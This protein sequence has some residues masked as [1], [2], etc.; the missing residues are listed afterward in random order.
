MKKTIKLK[1]EN[2]GN[3]ELQDSNYIGSGGEAN[4][5]KFNKYAVKVYH[6]HTKAI[7]KTKIDELSIIKHNNVLKPLHVAYNEYGKLAGY[8]MGFIDGSEPACKMFTKSFKNNN[9]ISI[10]DVTDLVKDIKAC[11]ES[12]HDAKC[13]VVDMN[14]MNIVLTGRKFNEPF[15]IDVD[16]YQTPTFKATAIMES[17]RDRQVKNHQWTEL[18]DW[19]SYAIL[20]FQMY[21]GIHPYKGTHPKYKANEWMVRMEDGVS[22]FDKKVSLPAVCNDFKVIPSRYLDWMKLLF[23]DNRR[24]VPPDID[25]SVPLAMPLPVKTLFVKGDNKFDYTVVEMFGV[26]EEVLDAINVFGVSYYVTNKS[27]YKGNARMVELDSSN[28]HVAVTKTKQLVYAV[29]G[30]RALDIHDAKGMQIG[31]FDCRYSNVMDDDIYIGLGSKL[32]RVQMVEI[33]S[34]T[35]VSLYDAANIMELSTK[36]FKGVVFQ[37]MLGTA[38]VTFPIDK[39][40]HTIKLPELAGYRVL[41]MKKVKNLLVVMAEKQGKYDKLMFL[42][43]GKGE[44]YTFRIMQNVSF[45]DLNFTV[46]ENGI[47]VIVNDG[48]SIEMFAD[49]TKVKTVDGTSFDTG[50]PIVSIANKVHVLDGNRVYFTTSK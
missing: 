4:V 28:V 21:V 11:V 17:I 27:I 39:G 5:Y 38:W 16:S 49:F 29:Q 15:M 7:P 22:V 20:C 45:D 50:I 33:G 6:D 25:K 24:E 19:Y 48:G 37:D 44:D 12:V 47:C 41:E 13:L 18:S 42:F 36:F 43:K 30:M 9:N 1:V 2:L 23:V 32:C 31:G 46:L 35:V 14:E 8:V 34:K 10:A 26:D 3:V 40:M